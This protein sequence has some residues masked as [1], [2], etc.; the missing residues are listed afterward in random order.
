M[1]EPQLDPLIHQPTRF[2][3]LLLLYRYRQGSASWVKETLNLTDGNLWGHAKRLVE[4]GYVEQG[5]TLTGAGFSVVLRITPAGS[6]AFK[7]YLASWKSFL[8]E[9]AS[10]EGPAEEFGAERS[11]V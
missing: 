3:V 5:R 9:D 11:R 1:D 4:G 7:A 2:R 6:D 10:G 8:G